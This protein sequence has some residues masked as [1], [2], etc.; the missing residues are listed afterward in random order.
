MGDLRR[1]AAHLDATDPLASFRDRFAI[2]DDLIYLDGNSLGRPPKTAID[3][4]SSVAGGEWPSELVMAWDHWLDIGLEIGDRLAPL[5]GADLGEVAICDQT[6]V[7][8][9]KVASAL[10]SA[11]DNKDIL[12][13]GGNFPSDRYV[14]EAI[15]EAHG[16]RLVIAP[17]DPTMDELAAAMSGVG[18][19]SLSHVS[20]RSGRMYDGGVVTDLAHRSG[21]LMLWDLA[22]SVG[23]V[24]VDLGAWGADA[25]VGCTYKY[26][27]AGPGAPGFLWVPERLHG[28]IRQPI[29]GWFSHES[30]FDF[31]SEYR[32]APSIRRFLVGT[33]PVISMV[34]VDEG[35]SLTT[36]AGMDDIRTKSV[37]LSELFLE[38]VDHRLG[39][40]AIEVASPRDAASRGSH[41]TLRHDKGYQL[42]TTLRDRGVITDFRAPDLVRFGFA[43]LYNT[44]T[45]VV[46]A[47]D[48]I[49]SVVDDG[50][51]RS[52]PSPAGE[53][54]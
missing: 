6:S 45:Q 24:H 21:A 36:E 52:R 1:R 39:D 8:L 23:A 51:Y 13:D 9:Y 7:N 10:L 40:A 3:R 43:P 31:A 53:V 54:T 16:G 2:D 27:N 38:A 46:E 47:V 18:L 33:P 17:E 20:Y 35:I 42:S 28:S 11:A 14:L 5:I 50:T 29:A 41:V 49:A 4:I 25:A 19:V 32:P 15:A 12:T 22:H 34:G 30:M 44:H 48:L 37:S 26:L